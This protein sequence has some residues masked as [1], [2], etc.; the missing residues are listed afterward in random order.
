MHPIQQGGGIT[1]FSKMAITA[2]IGAALAASAANAQ[3]Q[4]GIDVGSNFGSVPLVGTPTYYVSPYDNY[5]YSSPSYY[6]SP[7]ATYYST[8]GTT[9]YTPSYSSYY[10]SPG[11]YYYSGPGYYNGWNSG[12]YNGW[13]NRGYWR[14]GGRRWR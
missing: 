10:S 7:G 5:Y 1:M 14:G 13:S 6:V 11:Y 3:F 4:V 8:P 12:Y 9:Y 2:V